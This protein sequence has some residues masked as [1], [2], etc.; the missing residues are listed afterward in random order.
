MRECVRREAV[1]EA[2]AKVQALRDYYRQALDELKQEQ[3]QEQQQQQRA[4][5]A[6][7]DAR[8]EEE[9]QRALA[10]AQAEHRFAIDATVR[11]AMSHI[12]QEYGFGLAHHHH[13]Q[14]QQQQQQE[15]QQQQ[16]QQQQQQRQQGKE[17]GSR[18]Q[19]EQTAADAAG[20]SHN[21]MLS[22]ARSEDSLVKA[23]Q[24]LEAA[25]NLMHAAQDAGVVGSAAVS[26]DGERHSGGDVASFYS[27]ASVSKGSGP[28]SRSSTTSTP[29][30]S[31]L[32]AAH[33]EASAE[34]WYK[35]QVQG[36]VQALAAACAQRGIA[37]PP[38]SVLE[39]SAW[40]A[41][42][43]DLL[44]TACDGT[45]VASTERTKLEQVVRAWDARLQAV[46]GHG[47]LHMPR[48][49]AVV[50]G[51]SEGDAKRTGAH[52]MQQECREEQ[53][54]AQVGS[55]LG[56][57]A[58]DVEEQVASLLHQCHV[59][60]LESD[61]ELQRVRDKYRRLKDLVQVCDA[62]FAFVR[63]VTCACFFFFLC[64]EVGLFPLFVCSV[65]STL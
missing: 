33:S 1:A 38:A 39:F 34:T 40:E 55:L 56:G 65:F 41:A 24:E 2:E 35:V 37:C 49:T 19:Q 17:Q 52:H 22:S 4:W 58:K 53:E 16:Q 5:K 13:Q 42:V 12:K 60:L 54:L 31:S 32:H 47:A 7:L 43:A 64:F 14:Q 29:P 50:D 26:V 10:R 30:A 48:R 8:V 21:P 59:R 23:L 20:R 46:I 3:R 18:R 28:E 15:G 45:A 25:A 51:G 62:L 6:T 57:D 11:E 36:F 61:A 9:T 27:A 44:A 63:C